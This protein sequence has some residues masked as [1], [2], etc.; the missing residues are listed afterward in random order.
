M[1][2]SLPQSPSSSD[3]SVYVK[4]TPRPLLLDDAVKSFFARKIAKQHP[5]PPS[6]PF[7]ISPGIK[8]IRQRHT[9]P[10]RSFD[11]NF[12]IKLPYEVKRCEESHISLLKGLLS[13]DLLFG[14]SRSVL[15][16]AHVK[17]DRRG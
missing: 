17:K 11:A 7:K 2:M 8:E 9:L 4:S 13:G 14:Y 6:R 10:L 3:A 16:R 15:N 5:M 12:Y 1:R